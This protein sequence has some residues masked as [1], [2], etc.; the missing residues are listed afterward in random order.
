[1]VT[2]QKPSSSSS[3]TATSWRKRRHPQQLLLTPPGRHYFN[4]T[5][6]ALL[7]GFGLY[8]T[9]SFALISYDGDSILGIDTSNKWDHWH[10]DST[11]NRNYPP[12]L[13]TGILSRK[14]LSYFHHLQDEIDSMDPH[15]RCRRYGWADDATKQQ[16]PPRK[17]FHGAL[18]AEEPWEL[19]EIMAAETRGIFAGMVFVESNRTQSFAPRQ[20][21]RVGVHYE[22]LLSQ[23]F[24]TRVI[25]RTFVNETATLQGLERENWQRQ[26]ILKGWKQLGMTPDDLGYIADT[27]ESMTRDFLLAL[28]TCHDLPLLNYTHHGCNARRG[29]RLY[30]LARIWEGTPDCIT[31]QRS[32]HHPAV[33][34]GACIEGI[35][36]PGQGVVA[37]RENI[38]TRRQG[39]GKDCFFDKPTTAPILWNPADFRMILCG[40]QP[41]ARAPTND[42]DDD[43][44]FNHPDYA[45]FTGYHLHNFFADF[46]AIRHKYETYGHA[47]DGTVPTTRKRRPV[48]RLQD[49]HRDLAFLHACVRND[50][51]DA[52]LF[53]PRVQGGM[54]ALPKYFTPLYFQDADYRSRRQQ[55]MLEKILKEDERA[56]KE[57]E[58]AFS[59]QQARRV[60]KLD[61]TK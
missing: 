1:M 53:R 43:K 31:H 3:S 6:G 48:L 5:L 37:P 46:D 21:Q 19:L 49:R 28:K 8:L 42:N 10:D 32:G 59:Q 25:V 44:A 39:Y 30:A 45:R 24:D 52:S 47:M 55:V 13:P 7:F 54:E 61:L 16:Q 29:A 34:M 35:A 38:Y 4:Y 60:I 33:V 27:D 50:P 57:E 15:E 12:G 41:Q 9:L 56:T 11:N 23:L 22:S 36:T 26:E 18:L 17:I 2:I 20:L 40:D 58:S 14:P 51:E